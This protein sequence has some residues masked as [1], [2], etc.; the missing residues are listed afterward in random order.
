M[1]ASFPA[2][3]VNQKPADLGIQNRFSLTTSRFSLTEGDVD[4]LAA[5]R[6]RRLFPVSSGETRTSRSWPPWPRT[7]EQDDGLHM[8]MARATIVTVVILVCSIWM[9]IE[10]GFLRGT[11]GSNSNGSGPLSAA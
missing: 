5:S 8:V 10:I 2:S 9:L 7:I 11:R 6:G 1:L 3:L 4:H